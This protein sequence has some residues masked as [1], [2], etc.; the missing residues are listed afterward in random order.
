MARP[1]GLRRVF[2]AKN[3]HAGL[4]VATQ[5]QA[6][7]LIQLRCFEIELA[8][9]ASLLS[10]VGIVTVEPIDATV[11]LEVGLFE[12]SPNGR[13]M[14]RLGMSFIDDVGGDVIEAPTCGGNTGIFGKTRGD[15]DDTGAVFRGKNAAAYP[16]AARLAGRPS[17]GPRNACATWR[18]FV[19]HSGTR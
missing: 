19:G 3:L 12:D 14:H 7:L 5:N 10:E 1:S 4:L 13:T 15:G 6:A 2:S 8:D 18:R 9:F 17:R 16:V 11:G